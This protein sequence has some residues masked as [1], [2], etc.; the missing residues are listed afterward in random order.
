MQNHD[1]VSTRPQRVWPAAECDA[2]LRYEDRHRR[3][4][5]RKPGVQHLVMGRRRLRDG[6][7]KR[8]QAAD[9]TAQAGSHEVSKRKGARGGERPKLVREE[10]RK[11]PER[12]RWSRVR[13]AP[14]RT[15]ARRSAPGS[16][17]W[18]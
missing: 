12:A 18:R 5:A 10:V 13:P 17:R 14:A 8:A 9:E 2:A 3:P 4:E 7:R 16:R 1:L 6:R 11:R 15:A